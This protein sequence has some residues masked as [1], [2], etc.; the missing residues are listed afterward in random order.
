MIFRKAIWTLLLASLCVVSGSPFAFAQHQ[1]PEKWMPPR[2]ASNTPLDQ[3]IPLPVDD[4]AVPL[5]S[6]N[7]PAFTDQL[8]QK[9][10]QRFEHLRRQIEELGR[11]INT[12]RAAP[13]REV[14]PVAPLPNPPQAAPVQI[15][16]PE[17]E[18]TPPPRIPD[19][20]EAVPGHVEQHRPDPRANVKPASQAPIKNPAS[21][22]NAA[23]LPVVRGEVD[24]LSL[25]TSLYGCRDF[26]GCLHILTQVEL[27][28]RS[29]EDR[30]WAEYLQACCQ[31]KLGKVDQA[32]AGFRRILAEENAGWIGELAK[33]W[34]EHLGERVRLQADTQRLTQTLSNWEQVVDGLAP[35]P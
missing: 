10:E 28:Q 11:V 14:V 16:P 24:R 20:H 12:S 7:E 9:K 30:L 1:V 18:A 25:A 29:T 5:F 23:A 33:W 6:N 3:R 27:A 32:Q 31:S 22:A 19:Q 15:Q 35:K 13:P 17:I 26:D 21:E 4:I 2:T 8:Q 34:L